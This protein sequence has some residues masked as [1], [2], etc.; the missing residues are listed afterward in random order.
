MSKIF[1]SFL[2]L[3]YPLSFSPPETL[4]SSFSLTG[5]ILFRPTL[6]PA[7]YP[8]SSSNSGDLTSFWSSLEHC[9]AASK[10]PREPP[11]SSCLSL[12]WSRHRLLRLSSAPKQFVE[13]L[14]GLIY[15]GEPPRML[16]E[17]SR[18]QTPSIFF[19]HH[20]HS[21]AELPTTWGDS[22]ELGRS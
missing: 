17:E 3:P 11:Q 4:S 12:L 18:P 9:R 10:E 7:R 21:T 5:S 20:H 1:S 13:L 14:G 6:R 22:Y 19:M 8:R 15:V 16:H 2:S